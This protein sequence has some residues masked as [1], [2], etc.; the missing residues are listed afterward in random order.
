[1]KKKKYDILNALKGRIREEGYTYRS[2]SEKAG[3]S[4]DALNN[5]INGYSLLD[6][7]DI[8]I[9]VEILNIDPK[10]IIKYFFPKLL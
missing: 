5:K 10:D 6:T 3:I 2:L 8:S 1:M 7:K 4:L 9:L